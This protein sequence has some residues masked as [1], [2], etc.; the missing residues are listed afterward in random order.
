ML[1]SS[2]NNVMLSPV[3]H[4]RAPHFGR[5][6]PWKVEPES[7]NFP[8]SAFQDVNHPDGTTSLQNKESTGYPDPRPPLST[9]TSN[10][11]YVIL[12]VS[13]W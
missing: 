7:Y 9:V 10:L 2:D 11:L 4:R 5:G 1:S 3:S 12:E 13:N 6:P 8:P